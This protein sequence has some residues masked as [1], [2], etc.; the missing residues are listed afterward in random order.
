MP[1]PR[2]E[3]PPRPEPAP[4]RLPAKPSS[5]FEREAREAG[6]GCVAGLDEVGRGCL[7]GP[8]VAAAVV[9]DPERP[10]RGLNDSKVLLSDNRQ[11]I[12]AR[13]REHA[14][15]WA[16]AAVDSAWID[17]LNIYQASRL[18][19]ERAIARLSVQPDFL[20]TDAMRLE[21]PI[22]QRALIKGDAR[23]RSIAA[24]SILA[25]VERDDWMRRW[26]EVYP[27]YNLESNK[28]Y[29]T[30]DHLEALRR[31]GVTPCHRLSFAP[32]A[33]IA[34]FSGELPAEAAPQ[35]IS[36]FAEELA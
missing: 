19:M 13:I 4:A 32:V 15:A 23:C 26:A 25:K 33:A 22:P 7:F 5:R 24:A 21:L 1:A 31:H 17:R 10:V 27:Q 14:L 9:L 16:V 28:G 36:L 20:L 3:G 34:R 30:P 29:G 6:Y 18:A 35:Q 8:V 12:A 11:A 2:P